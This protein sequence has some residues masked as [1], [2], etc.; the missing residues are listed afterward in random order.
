MHTCVPAYI[1][2][3]THT[4]VIKSAIVSIVKSHT[5]IPTPADAAAPVDEGQSDAATGAGPEK[6]HPAPP[7]AASAQSTEPAPPASPQRPFRLSPWAVLRKVSGIA[8]AF[9]SAAQSTAGEAAQARAAAMS[10]AAV[11]SVIKCGFAEG[12]AADVAVSSPQKFSSNGNIRFLKSSHNPF[13]GS[14]SDC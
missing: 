6:R 2:T 8:S 12:K 7:T 11:C 14:R 13:N 9:A 5:A 10:E 1:H 4:H 3:H